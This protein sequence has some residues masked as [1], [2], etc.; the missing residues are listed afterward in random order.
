MPLP[1]PKLDQYTFDELVGQGQALLPRYAP[2][3]TDHNVHDPGITLVELFAWLAEMESY[4]LDRVTEANI[5]AFLRL[6]GIEPKPAQVAETVLMSLPDAFGGAKQ[7]PARTKVTTEDRSVTFQTT[8]P[9]WVSPAKLVAVLA[10]PAGALTDYTL[11]N[12]P[13]SKCFPSFAPDPQIGH[14]LYLGFDRPLADTPATINLYVW[15]DD[16]KQDGQTREL[17][18][19]EAN[20][21]EEEAK[22]CPPGRQPHTVDWR[23]HYSVRTV[24]EYYAGAEQW[25]PL[26]EVVDGTRAFTLSGAVRFI[27]P[28][29]SQHLPD[30]VSLSGHANRYFIRCRLVSGSYDCPPETRYVQMDGDQRYSLGKSNGRAGQNHLLPQ[31]PIV[32]GSTTLHVRISATVEQEWNEYLS[33]DRIGPHAHSYVLDPERGEVTLGNGRAGAVPK[34]E[35]ELAVTYQVG[36]GPTG[37]VLAGGLTRLF[38]SADLSEKQFSQPFPAVGGASAESLFEAKARAVAWLS[39]PHRAVTLKDF[40][41]LA[42]ATPGVPVGRTKA[43]ADYD[44]SLPCVPAPGAVTVVVLSKCPQTHPVPSPDLLRAVAQYLE[45]RRLLT[46]EVH[47][48][49]PEYTKVAVRATLHVTPETAVRELIAQATA[50]LNKFFD[51]ISGGPEGSGWPMGR[52]VYRSEILALLNAL[53][54]VVYV[55]EVILETVV[56]S[57]TSACECC[58]EQEKTIAT[59]CGNIKIC[60]HGL[61]VPGKHHITVSTERAVP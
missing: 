24:W 51:P 57:S 54:G 7:L 21:I 32:P 27:A 47:V 50:S 12:D 55:D 3:W 42:L 16:P 45:R 49:G 56:K 37:N 48:I 53:P 1:L 38:T 59:Q 60:P 13:S 40:E 18:K 5:R 17:L 28:E 25:L 8:H 30:G 34:A 46:T 26:S 41:R 43:L 14:A 61:V 31:Q 52:A 36:G 22:N 39:A 11:R 19:A 10:G 23:H 2:G 20:A 44:P 9:V 15:S 29:R 6:L 4:R 33:W 35:A 58:Q